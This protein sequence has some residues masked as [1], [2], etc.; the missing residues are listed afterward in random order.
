MFYREDYLPDYYKENPTSTDYD[1]ISR[2]FETITFTNYLIA[3]NIE[4]L[5]VKGWANGE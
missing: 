1:E 2:Q 3:T 5:L 4:P